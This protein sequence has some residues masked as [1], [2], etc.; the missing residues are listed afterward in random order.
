[1]ARKAQSDV[2]YSFGDITIA[3]TNTDRVMFPDV[4]IT[5]GELIA[6][7]H[8]IADTMLPELRDRPISVERFTKGV[9][10]GG[11]FQKH[12]QKHFPG[13][14]ERVE[15]G[16]K[17]RVEYPL[18]NTTAALVYMANQGSVVF[19]VWT[20][21]TAAPEHPDLL[22]FDLDPAE[23][24]FDSVRVTALRLRELFGELGLP[25]F[26]KTTG[27]KGLHVV[28]PLDGGASYGEVM[29]LC[30]RLAQLLVARHPDELTIEFYKKDRKGRLY[31]DVMRNAL[32]ATIVAAYSVR[33]RPGAPV[34]VPIE[35]REVDDPKLRPDGFH[36]REIQNRLEKLGDPWADLR[37]RPGSVAGADAALDRLMH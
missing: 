10:K 9:D 23:G 36:L 16:S 8:R 26:V 5:K 30:N 29:A 7:Y 3:C 33:G 2:E 11:F 13:W 32:G 37:A 34:S 6:Y 25:A 27:G 19:H 21:R 18:V 14:I 35:W 20:S 22:V 1:V 15:L 28:A 12:A 4:G 24:K 17:T 31:L